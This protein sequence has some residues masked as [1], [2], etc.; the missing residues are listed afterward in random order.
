MRWVA[1]QTEPFVR[2]KPVL[3]PRKDSPVVQRAY[4]IRNNF[5]LRIHVVKLSQ[6]QA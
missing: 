4:L 3:P 1:L 6:K 2:N 5:K